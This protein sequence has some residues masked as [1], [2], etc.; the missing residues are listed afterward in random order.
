LLV[1]T[2]LY[3]VLIIDVPDIVFHDKLVNISF[4]FILKMCTSKKSSGGPIIPHGGAW[5][6][7]RD[8]AHLSHFDCMLLPSAEQITELLTDVNVSTYIMPHLRYLYACGILWSI[9]KLRHTTG[10]TACCVAN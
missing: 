8:R 3:P 10:L 4:S 2:C 7:L 9:I 1:K 5:A 6:E